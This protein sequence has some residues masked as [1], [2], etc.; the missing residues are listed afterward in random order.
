VLGNTNANKT[1]TNFTSLAPIPVFSGTTNPI[2]ISGI[3]SLTTSTAVL[4]ASV[5]ID[6]DQNGIYDP[7]NEL[8]FNGTGNFTG[9]NVIA[10]SPNLPLTALSGVTGMRAMLYQSTAFTPCG[11]TSAFTQG[12]TEDYLVNI[13]TALPCSGVPST[14]VINS[15]DV[16]V[17]GDAFTLS[18]DTIVPALGISY[19]WTA[20]STPIAAA[21]GPFYSSTQ[22]TT[23]T[24]QLTVSC[25]NGGTVTSNTVTIN[26]NPPDSCYCFTGL[27]GFCTSV[28]IDG[29]RISKKTG[30]IF[31]PTTLNNQNNGCT[32]AAGQA[33]S[34]FPISSGQYAVLAPTDTFQLSVTNSIGTPIQ[35]KVW[36]D[37]NKDGVWNNTNELTNICTT[38]CVSGTNSAQFLINPS[39]V[40]GDTVRIR[41]RTRSGTITD[42][43]QSIGSGETED[44]F[45]I[46]GSSTIL[47]LNQ[48]QSTIVSAIK[49]FPNPTT[50]ILN[51]EIPTNVSKA[52]ITVSDLLGRTIVSKSA[53]NLKSIDLSEFK[54]GIYSVIVNLDGK[55]TYS[56]IILNK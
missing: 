53:N 55:L 29:F 39:A 24:Y 28:P 30:S 49:L 13:T 22:S 25:I 34:V 42:A 10:G 41:V 40:I 15:S 14:I 43:C 1:Y 27:G 16:N 8:F 26:Q 19:S 20:N 11:P 21:T 33:Y 18:V 12:E 44:Y 9:S 5:Y 3:T 4:T 23:T 45:L 6:Y 31:T 51:F 46:V 48:L 2:S 7:V 47:S 52:T 38:G 54:N 17:C 36:T 56:N 50:G 35:V 32:T 37:W